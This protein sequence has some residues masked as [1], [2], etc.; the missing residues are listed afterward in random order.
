MVVLPLGG[1][2]GPVSLISLFFG[3]IMA[4]I[5]MPT[6]IVQGI[7]VDIGCGLSYF[8]VHTDSLMVANGILRKNHIP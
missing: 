1:F 5:V 4:S 3:G 8:L 2:C 7:K 6:G